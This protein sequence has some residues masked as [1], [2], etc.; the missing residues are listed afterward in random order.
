MLKIRTAMYP[1]SSKKC[2]KP[3]RVTTHN[4]SPIM[5]SW[6][7]WT[8]ITFAVWYCPWLCEI[9]SIAYYLD[10]FHQCWVGYCQAQTL[11]CGCVL[12]FT[13]SMMRMRYSSLF[14]TSYKNRWTTTPWFVFIMWQKTYLNS[15]CFSYVVVLNLNFQ[16][17]ISW[18][19]V[20][21]NPISCLPQVQAIHSLYN[22]TLETVLHCKECKY[23]QSYTSFLLSLPLHIKEDHNSLVSCALTSF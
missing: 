9:M 1:C 5:T 18:S 19:Y 22:V 21:W 17:N 13:C 7:V 16:L 11:C 10:W 3:C 8:T 6:T 12:Q 15:E 23:I 2:S 20:S 4:Q 14:W